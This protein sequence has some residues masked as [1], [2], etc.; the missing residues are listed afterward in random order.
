MTSNARLSPEEFRAVFDAAPDGIV[1]VDRDGR[2]REVNPQ[3][4]RM[5][6]WSRD[7][8]LGREI[9]VLVPEELREVHRGERS[10]YTDSPHTRPM[11]I[12][13]QL[14]GRRKDG[15]RFPVEISLSPVRRGEDL[16]VIAAVRDVS[17]RLRLR[18]FGTLTL[19]AAEEERRRIAREL[20]DDTAQR[21]AT[22]LLRLRMAAG[23]EAEDRDRILDEVRE[24]IQETVEGIR[25]IARG[26]RPPALEEVG[27][28]AALRSHLRE[29]SAATEVE[30]DLTDDLSASDFEHRLDPERRLVLYRVVQEAVSN[31][32]RHSGTSSVSVRLEEAGGRARAVVEDRGRGFDPEAVDERSGGLGLIGMEERVSAVGGR[33]EIDS[34]KGR[35]T[36]V[37]AEVP[38]GDGAPSDGSAER[39]SA[40]V[41]G[42]GDRSSGE[43]AR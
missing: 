38:A 28:V 14:E 1:V 25:R 26:L 9:E 4:E 41:D 30:A 22:V 33:L 15:S 34:E 43:T 27:L 35:G 3:V 31:A 5:F 21:L 32:L 2:I 16:H 17:E 11:G 36:R 20:H 23:S 8:L 13:M 39:G 7:D 40:R 12:G 42:G 19:R 18:R 10:D 24:A 37:V 6:G 29:V